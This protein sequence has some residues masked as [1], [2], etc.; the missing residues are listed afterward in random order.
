MPMTDFYPCTSNEL[1]RTEKALNKA[2]GDDD[3]TFFSILVSSPIQ[4]KERKKVE[5][6]IGMCIGSCTGHGI[7]KMCARRVHFSDESVL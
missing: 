7:G 5:G 1:L 3:D 6:R 4:F 2:E